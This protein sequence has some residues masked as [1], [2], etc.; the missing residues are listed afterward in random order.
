MNSP[1]SKCPTHNKAV[2]INVKPSAL[3]GYAGNSKIESYWR[4]GDPIFVNYLTYNLALGLLNQIEN[5]F[6]Y[7]VTYSRNKDSAPE[8]AEDDGINTVSKPTFCTYLETNL[9]NDISYKLC[10]NVFGNLWGQIGGNVLENWTKS[11]ISGSIE[12]ANEYLN[13]QV[14]ADETT[15]PSYA[16]N[17]NFTKQIFSSCVIG[18]QCTFIAD[19]KSPIPIVLKGYEGMLG[20]R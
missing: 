10:H 12:F 6:G 16:L 8:N 7:G 2:L 11:K 13:V 17:I 18:G 20:Y 5:R 4:P 3:S 9:N 1:M 14:L 15:D 19:K